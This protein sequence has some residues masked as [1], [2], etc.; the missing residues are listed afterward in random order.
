MFYYA[1]MCEPGPCVHMRINNIKLDL[2]DIALWEDKTWREKLTITIPSPCRLIIIHKQLRLPATTNES[3][4]DKYFPY[5][6]LRAFGFEEILIK[7]INEPNHTHREI[8]SPNNWISTHVKLARWKKMNR[9]AELAV[10]RT[11]LMDNMWAWMEFEKQ[12][13]HKLA[14]Q[15]LQCPVS[16]SANRLLPPAA[17][18]QGFSYPHQLHSAGGCYVL[19]L[20]DFPLN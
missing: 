2:S 8:V 5:H 1:G 7:L 4:A 9:T 16:K 3:F 12:F 10:T 14:L 17:P 19:Q 6:S 11:T 15:P 18:P 20:V 13:H